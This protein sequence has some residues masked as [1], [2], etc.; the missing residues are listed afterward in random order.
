M[1]QLLQDLRYSVRVLRRNPRFTVICLVTLMLG[2]GATTAIFSVVNALL[3][4]PLPYHEPDRLVAVFEDESAIGFPR[5]KVDP[6]T[7]GDLVAQHALFSGVAH[8][9]ETSFNFARNGSRARL[10]SG[11]L[12]TPN[13]F[14]LLDVE[15][16]LGRTFLP[17][18]GEPGREH[19]VLLSE[20]LWRTT[21]G[22]DPGVVGRTLRLNDEP[23]VVVGVMPQRFTFPARE[24]DQIDVWAPSAL[25]PLTQYKRFQRFM[26]VVARMHPGVSLAQANAALGVLTEQARRQSSQEMQT[27]RRFYG[28]PLQVSNTGDVRGG[29]DLLMAAVALI[30]L[31]ACANV[32]NLLLSRAAGRQREIALRSALG[33]TQTRLMRQLFTESLL[34]AVGGGA[35]GVALAV[36]SFGALKQLLPADLLAGVSLEL[37]LPVLAFA[38]V[39][40]LGSSIVFGLA[41]ALYSMKVEL[42]TAL[43]EGSK[44]SAGSRRS[45]LGQSFVVAE[46]AMSVVLLMGAG[47][48]LK[49][50]WNLEHAELGF[51]PIG[52]LTADF[53]LGEARYRNWDVQ[54][55]FV[56]RVLEKLQALPGAESA[57][58]TS[59]LPMTWK[60][61]TSEYTPEG[62]GVIENRNTNE[63]VITEGYLE[64]IGDPLVRGRYFT[65]DDR[66]GAP[67]VA[68]VNRTMAEAFWPGQQAL[69]K[70]LKEGRLSE[71]T[72][73]VTVVGVVGD[74]KQMGVNQPPGQEVYFPFRQ[75]RGN[76]MWPHQMVVRAHVAPEQLTREVEDAVAEVDSAEPLFHVRAMQDL[77]RHDTQQSRME[78]I[79]LGS[80]AALALLMACVGIYGVMSYMVAQRTNEM[81]IRLALGAQTSHILLLVLR[82]GAALALIGMGLGAA[83]A[84]M[85][86]RFMRSLLYGVA[87]MDPV[88][89]GGV[90]LLL[91]TMVLVACLVPARRAASVNPLEAIR[92]E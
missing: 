12:V 83:L 18:E 21:F 62:R 46:I 85:L 30:L 87:P 72:P 65:T 33:A 50:L 27:V 74:V 31:I 38:V 78:T 55:R 47:L 49:S 45:L 90:C 48:L 56:A 8:A 32:T 61:G 54:T 28:E 92:M 13:L 63:R 7:Y 37:S 71:N 11:V 44:T 3:I 76:Y 77:M 52:I 79:V 53:D 51:R 84:L 2:I 39:C 24:A 88:T 20:S 68:I 1:S 29:L 23:Y 26:Q 86:A 14:S 73:W 40:S 57:G 70:R 82:R 22:G 4:E 67:L 69:G 17:S 25:G 16:L 81:G 80:L 42:N 34:L 41:P 66:E 43:K 9:N 15:P 91:T 36:A 75:A 5:A 10:L 19:E 59:V 58:L 89:L 6:P 60:G 64:T 35:A